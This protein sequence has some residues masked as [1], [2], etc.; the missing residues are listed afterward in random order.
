MIVGSKV[1]I[2]LIGGGLMGRETASALARW[3]ALLDCP[4]G[5]ELVAVCDREPSALEWFKSIST[6][7]LLT[8]DHHALLAR[9]D[10]DVVYAAVPHDQHEAIYLD[11]LRAGKDLLAEKPFGIDLRAAERIL[12][13]SRRLGRFVRVSS[14]FPFLPGAQKVF[15]LARQ[16]EFGQLLQISAGFRHSSDLDPDKPINWKR[17]ARHCGQAG[18]MGDLGLHVVHLPLRLGWKP[19]SLYAQLQ[20]IVLNRPDGKGGMA[21]CDTWDNALLSTNVRVGPDVV[22][23]AFEMK[24]IAPGE[25]NTWFVEILG[26]KGGARFSTKEPKTFWTFERTPDQAWRRTDLGFTMPFRVISGQIFEPGFPDVLQQMWAA[27]LAERA[28]V[29]GDRFGCATP[30]EA[31]ASHAIWQAALRSQ[32]EPS[33]IQLE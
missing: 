29:L 14:E 32:R 9:S 2:G 4:V 1:G 23:M 18:V 11:V 10:V 28:G 8:T 25:T 15:R 30:E 19:H 3:C 7:K 5:A 6:A 17:Q 12:T 24:R 27:Y 13:E 26:L 31:T 21:P 20:K 33:V 16:G 22:P